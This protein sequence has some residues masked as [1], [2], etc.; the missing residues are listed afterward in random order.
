MPTLIQRGKNLI[1]VEFVGQH[2]FRLGV[3]EAERIMASACRAAVMHRA[4]AILTKALHY[5]PVLTG[6]LR[7]SGRV[8]RA[9]N[10]ARGIYVAEVVFG[11]VRAPYAI[12]VHEI[13]TRRHRPPTRSKFLYAAMQEQRGEM[14]RA[15][16]DLLRQRL[17][18]K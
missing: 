1:T 4:K 12:D 15:V 13:T 10:E 18:R 9:P 16:V 2:T 14:Q 7:R 8:R 6:R 11:G 5:C 17:G 3:A